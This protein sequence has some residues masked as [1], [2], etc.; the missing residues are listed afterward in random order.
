MMEKKHHLTCVVPENMDLR[1]KA[2]DNPLIMELLELEDTQM[3]KAKSLLLT[4][5]NPMMK[6]IVQTLLEF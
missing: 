4:G 2:R 6:D 1:V 3:I 5:L